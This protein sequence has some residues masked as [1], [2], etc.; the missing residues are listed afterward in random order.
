MVSLLNRNPT[1]RL[2][3]GADGATEIMKHPFFASID[4]K[5]I[6]RKE[7][8]GLPLPRMRAEDYNMQYAKSDFSTKQINEIFEEERHQTSQEDVSSD[9]VNVDGWSFVKMT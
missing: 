8:E 3:A 4:F 5:K 2:G 7:V 9:G 1:R 6:G